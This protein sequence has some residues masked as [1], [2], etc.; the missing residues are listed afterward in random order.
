MRIFLLLL[1]ATFAWCHGAAAEE[2]CK[3]TQLKN[4]ALTLSEAYSIGAGHAKAWRPDAAPARVGNTS[5]GPFQPDG[6]SIAWNLMFYSES[7]KASLSVSTFRGMLT[8][9]AQPGSAGRIPDLKP[10]FF[11]DGAKLY[12]IGK[13]KGSALLAQ[14]YFMMIDT[15][16]APG[17]RHATWYI[18]YTNKDNKN[19][20]LTVIID[21]NTGAVEKVLK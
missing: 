19:G 17:T 4:P 7:A 16:A 18:N 6:S 21:A 15:A 13:D 20:D 12:A 5:L 14:G 9:W 1:A 2:A 8:C 3:P 11:R 10:D